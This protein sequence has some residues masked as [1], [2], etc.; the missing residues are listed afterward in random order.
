MPKINFNTCLK[1]HDDVK[2]FGLHKQTD[3]H[4]YDNHSPCT[5]DFQLYAQGVLQNRPS[6]QPLSKLAL[7]D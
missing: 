6:G 5:L 1:T 7:V 4:N 3:K 2:A